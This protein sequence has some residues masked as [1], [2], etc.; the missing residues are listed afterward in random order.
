MLEIK[1]PMFYRHRKS[2][3]QEQEE[4]FNAEKQKKEKRRKTKFLVITVAVY[5]NS[6][7]NVKIYL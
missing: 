2:T 3:L 4:Y 6:L 1:P 5:W 7:Q